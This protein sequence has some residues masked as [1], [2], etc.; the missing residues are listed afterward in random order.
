M[1]YTARPTGPFTGN[2]K[3]YYSK[4]NNNNNNINEKSGPKRDEIQHTKARLGES[5]KGKIEKQSNACAVH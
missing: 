2:R 5:F 4:N 3:R 1:P